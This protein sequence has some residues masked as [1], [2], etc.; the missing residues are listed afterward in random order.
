M[1]K[2]Q[3]EIAMRPFKSTFA[4]KKKKFCPP[5]LIPACSGRPPLTSKHYS[6]L[7]FAEVMQSSLSQISIT[8]FQS[9]TYKT[10]ILTCTSLFEL[11]IFSDHTISKPE[12]S[13]YLCNIFG[14]S[15]SCKE[16]RF[17]YSAARYFFNLFQ[18]S[19]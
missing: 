10:V 3:E 17:S 19:E 8:I 16:K 18:Y 11:I 15:L 14:A 9:K 4:Q 5:A 12:F 6:N 2:Q 13:N 1:K 7:K